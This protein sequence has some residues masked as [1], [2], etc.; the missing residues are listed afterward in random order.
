M[1]TI[2]L[3]N[4]RQDNSRIKVSNPHM[5]EEELARW[6]SDARGT[7][8]PTGVDQFGDSTVTIERPSE[9]IVV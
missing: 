7:D 9:W 2:E 1:A 8:E 3:I 6:W 5:T 4:V